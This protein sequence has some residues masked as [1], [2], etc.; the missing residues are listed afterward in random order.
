VYTKNAG[1][2]EL[3]A[4]AAPNSTDAPGFVKENGYTFTFGMADGIA[5]FEQYKVEGIP[6]T[7][8]IDRQGNIKEQYV[9]GMSLEEFEGKLKQIL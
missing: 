8:F 6:V 3:V 5:A 1:K 2:F 9:G 7:I 4:I